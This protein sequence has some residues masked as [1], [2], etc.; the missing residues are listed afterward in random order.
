[1]I[2]ME[3]P[4]LNLSLLINMIEQSFTRIMQV[5]VRADLWSNTD[6]FQ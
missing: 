1:M 3:Q 5:M 4:S 2:F 6:G